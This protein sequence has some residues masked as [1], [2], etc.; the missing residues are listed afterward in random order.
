MRK[1][2]FGVTLALALIAPGLALAQSGHVEA[3]YG[4]LTYDFGFGDFDIDAA[5]IGGQAAFDT[6]GPVGIQL[7]GRYSNWGGD[8]DDLDIWGIGAHAFTRNDAW[9]LGGYLGY[10]EIDDFNTETWTGAVEGQLYMPRSTVSAVLSHSLWDGPDYAITILEGEYRYFLSDNFSVHGGLGVG[11]GDIGSSDP[12]I[13]SGEVGA[14][15]QFAAAPISVFGFYR[16]D[17]LDFGTGDLEVDAL[18]IGLR[19]N[20]G[21]T[22]MD[23]NRS[24]AGL[25]RVRPLFERFL[26]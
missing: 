26:S 11:Q 4:N 8:A 12:D 14:E 6:G 2:L 5:S 1:H 21:G 18:S 22:L 25:N 17:E 23:R 15:L 13:L 19:Y 24:G 3:A 16:H 20:W 10:D 7:D 9:L